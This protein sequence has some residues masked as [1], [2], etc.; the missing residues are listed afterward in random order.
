MWLSFA[1]KRRSQFNTDKSVFFKWGGDKD[2]R[3]ENEQGWQR[4]KTQGSR[5]SQ[6]LVG[7]LQQLTKFPHR[8]C[9][10]DLLICL[11]GGFYSFSPSR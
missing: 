2:D 5:S 8:F 9:L 7:R 4:T 6:T 11:L 10:V 1:C 3:S